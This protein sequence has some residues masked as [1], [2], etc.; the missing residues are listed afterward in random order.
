MRRY[1]ATFV[2]RWH[3]N[4][5]LGHT[6]DT[7]AGH[8]GRMSVLALSIF[9]QCSR[10]LLAACVTHDLGE[11]VTGD[12]PYNS[13]I[14]DRYKERIASEELGLLVEL[15]GDDKRR[16]KM[17]DLLDAYLWARHHAPHLM[18][19][20]DWKKQRQNILDTASDLG[21][22]LDSYELEDK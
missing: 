22:S 4:P 18:A 7:L 15:K 8:G 12:V 1:L 2:R 19:R 13:P 16:L 21:V 6:V 3:T 5:D 20:Q 11:A 14:K 17:L 10:D 9:P